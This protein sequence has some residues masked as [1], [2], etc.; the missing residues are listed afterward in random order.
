MKY[1]DDADAKEATADVVV[2]LSVSLKTD[3][4]LLPNRVVV[5]LSIGKMVAAVVTTVKLASNFK[6]NQHKY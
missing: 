4:A 2:F 3:V 5:S 6:S 1:S